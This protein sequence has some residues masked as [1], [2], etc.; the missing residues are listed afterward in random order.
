MSGQVA[1]SFF[2]TILGATIALPWLCNI[3]VFRYALERWRPDNCK[4]IL[5]TDGAIAPESQ[6]LCQGMENE[7]LAKKSNV[8]W[9]RIDI[10]DESNKEHRELWSSI[11]KDARPELPY[12]LVQTSLGQGKLVN[13]WRGSLGRLSKANL[14]DSPVRQKL[15]QRILSGDSA[16]WLI[17]KSSDNVGSEKVKRRLT[18]QLKSL[19]S[20]LELPEGI[21]LPGSELHSEVPLLLRFTVIEIDPKDP[22]EEYLTQLFSGFHPEA[23]I[24]NDPLVI[25]VFGRGRALEVIPASRLDEGLIGDLAKFFTTACS[26]QV[27]EKNP[28]F[29][30]LLSVDWNRELFGEFGVVPSQDEGE[31]R[32]NSTPSRPKLLTIPPGKK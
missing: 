11:Q 30:L 8:E 9:T 5:F 2:L 20:Q 22:Q 29:D 19:E 21:G 15:I 1:K 12:A 28:G 27:K 4:I 31:K 26:C 3:P 6:T 7:G 23:L 32:T 16:V 10:R 25:P 18:E 24:A 14:L 13:N 17:L